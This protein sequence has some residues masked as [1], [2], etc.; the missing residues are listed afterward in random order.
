MLSAKEIFTEEQYRNFINSYSTD[1]RMSVIDFFLGFF[2][3]RDEKEADNRPSDA[4]SL[5]PTVSIE[6]LQEK[7]AAFVQGKIDANAFYIVLKGAFGNK[8]SKD[9]PEILSSLPKERAEALKKVAK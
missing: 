5:K 9:L 8:L 4:K 2:K 1:E 3:K 6:V 7:T